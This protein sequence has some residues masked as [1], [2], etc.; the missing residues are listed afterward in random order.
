MNLAIIGGGSWGTALAVVLAPKFKE[1]RLWMHEQD[2]AE[3]ITASRQNHVFLPGVRI[4]DSVRI[5]TVLN[6]SVEGAGIVLGVMPSHFAREIYQTLKPSLNKD[7]IFVSATKGIERGSLLRMSQIVE[8]VLEPEF[9]PQVAALSGP[10]FAREVAHGE[11]AAVVVASSQPQVAARVQALFSGPTF[12]LYTNSDPVGVEIAAAL[13]NVIAIAAGVC[14]GLGLGSNTQ[15]ALITRGLAEI[16]RLAVA[17]GGQHKTLAGLAGLGDLVLTCSGD[18]SRNR[19]VGKELASG[20]S[21]AEITGSMKMIAEGVE[22][23][24]AA[25]ALGR[26]FQVDLP[27]IDQMYAVLHNSKSPKEAIRELMDRS[28]KP[29]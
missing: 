24:D 15:A 1:V 19:T 8:Q 14:Q 6:D 5:T 25:V 11:P 12:R 16:T 3:R 2:L 20:K 27:I 4:P 17:M 9:Q 18:L 26:K 28:L 7:M 10:T 22:T 29:E 21:L 13:K 23:C